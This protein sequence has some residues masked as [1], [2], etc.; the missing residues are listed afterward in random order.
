ML[1][2]PGGE[3]HAVADESLVKEKRLH[4]QRIKAVLARRGKREKGSKTAERLL[5]HLQCLLHAGDAEFVETGKDDDFEKGIGE[6]AN[7]IHGVTRQIAVTIEIAAA[8]LFQASGRE[9]GEEPF[10]TSGE[11]FTSEKNVG[12]FVANALFARGRNAA[13]AKKM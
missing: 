1:S 4:L 7:A 11:S 10:A 2:K 12:G 3:L 13:E 6:T 5:I 8:S 9:T